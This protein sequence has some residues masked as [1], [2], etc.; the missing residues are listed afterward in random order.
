[1]DVFLFQARIHVESILQS[2][3]EIG[4]VILSQTLVGEE[5]KKITA[6]TMC[7]LVLREEPNL[8]AMTVLTN[9][10][11]S[12]QLASLP[13][14]L[15]N[16]TPFLDSQVGTRTVELRSTSLHGKYCTAIHVGERAVNTPLYGAPCVA[17]LL[18]WSLEDYFDI[19][20]C[21]L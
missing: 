10:G 14:H 15:V 20:T 4:S 19:D 8:L 5:P 18:T 21:S 3:K 9:K 1:M 7:L 13:I 6:R 11:N 17:R 12:F 16:V 2:L